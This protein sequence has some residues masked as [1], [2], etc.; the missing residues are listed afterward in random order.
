[1]KEQLLELI[2]NRILERGEETGSMVQFEI[3]G[4]FTMLIIQVELKL[5][6]E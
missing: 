2:E 4:L 6:K 3:D 1:M 5:S